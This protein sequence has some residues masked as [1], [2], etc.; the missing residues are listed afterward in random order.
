MREIRVFL[1]SPGDLAPE[2][3]LFFE[4]LPQLTAVAGV[5]FVPLGYE[6][7]PSVTGERPQDAIN[8]LVDSSDVVLT[9]F[10]RHWGQSTTDSVVATS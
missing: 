5:R 8:S 7:L 4:H 1:A 3:R 10:Y 6:L 9:A 2:R